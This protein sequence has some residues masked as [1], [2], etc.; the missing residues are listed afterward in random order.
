VRTAAVAVVMRVGAMAIEVDI[1]EAAKRG[2]PLARGRWD[3]E[4]AAT[5][6]LEMVPEAV[7]MEEGM[8]AGRVQWRGARGAAG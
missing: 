7:A 8:T 1:A 3:L 4:E 5:G 6:G 2:A